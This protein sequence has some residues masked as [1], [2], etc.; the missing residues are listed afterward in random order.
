M[1]VN[2]QNSKTRNIKK[3]IMSR[4][5]F[6]K[7]VK[8]NGPLNKNLNKLNENYYINMKSIFDSDEKKTQLFSYIEKLR[9]KDRIK[10]RSV[11]PLLVKNNNDQFSNEKTVNN[12]EK[13]PLR[14][15]SSDTIKNKKMIRKKEKLKYD[16]TYNNTLNKININDDIIEN[17]DDKIKEKNDKKKNENFEK[18][19]SD[20]CIFNIYSLDN[21]NKKH[22]YGTETTPSFRIMKKKKQ[23]QMTFTRIHFP[24]K[25]KNNI[26]KKYFKENF[27]F[28]IKPKRKRKK[29]EEN[30]KNLLQ[31]ERINNFCIK[32]KININKINK[33]K[34][35][36]V[37]K[38]KDNYSGY[39]LIKFD[40]GKK[41][42]EI[43][44]NNSI[45]VL[46][47]K[48]EE[49]KI[50]INNIPLKFNYI[51]QY[52][53]EID[54]TENLYILSSKVKKQEKQV[55]LIN[56]GMNTI[57]DKR[58]FKEIGI[59]VSYNIITS[60][61]GNN[62]DINLINWN[63]YCY[64]YNNDKINNN[65]SFQKNK[66]VIKQEKNNNNLS[67]SFH[68]KIFHEGNNN[69]SF[70]EDYYNNIESSEFNNDETNN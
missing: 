52:T 10:Q 67:A 31:I 1:E 58:K 5:S 41:I 7:L 45:D 43:P 42:N 49:E 66:K 19:Y 59:E 33:N 51:N 29:K 54:Q 24:S 3:L 25:K 60:N 21:I 22:Y 6:Q 14:D 26:V 63:K 46:N 40:K 65:K 70:Y 11:S 2:S 23:L 8:Q 27:F 62:T 36:E 56:T 12:K 44:F 39:K 30:K 32:S 4:D 47:K 53:N 61:S 55:Y 9:V 37:I 28:C 16:N 18:I 13:N 68:S 64:N 15:F 69:S 38:K 34:L 17:K 57:K 50:K 48:F 20:K 35:N